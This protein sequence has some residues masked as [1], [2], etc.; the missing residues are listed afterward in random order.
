MLNPEA[1]FY[2]ASTVFFLRKNSLHILIA[3]LI[4]HRYPYS[5]STCIDKISFFLN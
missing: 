3:F 4:W 2:K 1:F 5:V